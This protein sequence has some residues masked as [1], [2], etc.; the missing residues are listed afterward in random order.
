MLISPAHWI[1]GV[2]PFLLIF[3]NLLLCQLI[4]IAFA[5]VIFGVPLFR[6]TLFIRLLLILSATRSWRVTVITRIRV[7]TFTFTTRWWWTVAVRFRI[8]GSYMLFWFFYLNQIKFNSWLIESVLFFYF[9]LILKFSLS[10]CLHFYVVFSLDGI[11]FAFF[12]TALRDFLVKAKAASIPPAKYGM[13]IW[14]PDCCVTVLINIFLVFT[15]YTC[16]AHS[17]RLDSR[18][19]MRVK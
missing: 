15:S 19:L 11:N 18:L 2:L 9:E 16:Q 3:F 10:L 12:T 8:W 14:A 4:V 7:I 6:I 5:W 1:I 17:S 13:P